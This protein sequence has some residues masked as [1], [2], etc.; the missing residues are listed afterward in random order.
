[1]PFLLAGAWLVLG[2]SAVLARAG[3]KRPISTSFSS[4]CGGADARGRAPVEQ[5]REAEEHG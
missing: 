4:W 1:V 5:Q 3:V 2:V